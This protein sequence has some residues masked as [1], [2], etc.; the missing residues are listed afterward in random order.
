ISKCFEN[1]VFQALGVLTRIY[2]AELR[3]SMD[4]ENKNRV[5]VE[6]M[7]ACYAER[8]P[9]APNNQRIGRFAKQIG[10]RLT[11]QMVKGQIISFYIKDD[12][13]K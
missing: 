10:F 12:I 5:S 11:K 13:S 7:R 2:A 9:Y 6:D 4:I 8:F 3:K 1:F